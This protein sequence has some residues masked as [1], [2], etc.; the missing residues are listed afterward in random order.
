MDYKRI[1]RNRATREKILKILS[2]VPDKQM[3]QLQYRIKMGRKLDLKNPKRFTEKLQW[4][5]LNCHMPLMRQ[6]VDKYEVRDYVRQSGYGDILIPIV[7]I[8]GTPDKIDYDKLPNKCVIKDTLGSGGNAVII[9]KNKA[10]LNWNAIQKQMQQW[11]GES[12]SHK[13]GGREWPYGGNK[14]RILVEEFLESKPEEGGLI[15]YKFFCFNGKCEYVY[16]I[17]DRTVG[18]KAG[19]GIYTSDYI[20]LDVVRCD[21]KPLERYIKKPIQYERMLEIAHTLSKPFPEARIDLYEVD[22]KIRFGEITFFDGSGYMTF[23]PDSFDE[24]MGEK[25]VLP[26]KTRSGVNNE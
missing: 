10:K 12:I 9:C 22:G 19:L 8:Y 11:V 16:V 1:I 15:D 25:F 24:K 4:Y 20:K 14:H 3:I 23:A 6:C 17:A 2:L 18:K 13:K 7:G 21:E 5:K 26:G